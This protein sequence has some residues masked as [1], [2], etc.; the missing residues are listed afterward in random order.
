[1]VFIPAPKLYLASNCK[2]NKTLVHYKIKIQLSHA[3]INPI[4]YFAC[5]TLRKETDQPVL[6]ITKLHYFLR[7]MV[8]YLLTVQRL[9]C[10]K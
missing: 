4:S 6:N 2:Q 9:S 5:K 1:M 10:H 7:Q 3:N 8:K